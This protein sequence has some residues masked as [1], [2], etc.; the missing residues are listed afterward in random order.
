MIT[1]YER[2]QI[3]ER[4]RRGKTHRAKAGT[5]NVLSGAPF[6]YRYVR[7]NDHAEVCYQIVSHEAA[8]VAELFARYADGG[9]AIGALARW[10]S[11][12]G[13]P[14]RTGEACWDRSVIWAMLRKPRPGRSGPLRCVAAGTATQMRAAPHHKGS[15]RPGISRQSRGAFR[16]SGTT[17]QCAISFKVACALVCNVIMVRSPP[18]RWG[19]PVS[20]VT[21]VHT[22]DDMATARCDDQRRGNGSLAA[23]RRGASVDRS[24][25]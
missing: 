9:V 19:S 10:L 3:L 14:N 17:E 8:I 4:T 22:L 12:L 24:G 11:G 6:G 13:A 25:M 18:H 16:A 7:K 21:A 1:E 15:F 20:L 23:A 5:V 2:A